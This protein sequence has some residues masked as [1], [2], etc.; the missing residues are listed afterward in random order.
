MKEEI[1]SGSVTPGRKEEKLLENFPVNTEGSMENAPVESSISESN[2]VQEKIEEG[3]GQREAALRKVREDLGIANPE[4]NIEKPK[5]LEFTPDMWKKYKEIRLRAK[6]TDA[7][8]FGE[9]MLTQTEKDEVYWR[10]LLSD[11]NIRMFGAEIADK[12]VA[13]AGLQ[14]KP[15]GHFVLRR[16]YTVPEMRRKGISKVLTDKVF[17]EAK[18]QNAETI[19]LDVVE[20]ELAARAMYEGLGFKETRRSENKEMK[21]DGKLHRRIYMEKDLRNYEQGQ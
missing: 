20:E 4:E 17:A 3:E 6:E 10:E 18:R 11:P 12:I 19:H 21:G 14:K 2:N 16:V 15:E 7:Q 9:S 13:T 8:S 5:I 1:P